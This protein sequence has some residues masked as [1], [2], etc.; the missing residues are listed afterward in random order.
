MIYL[1]HNSK[2]GI[3]E[4]G[5]EQTYNIEAAMKDVTVVHEFHMAEQRF[6]EKILKNLNR[7]AGELKFSMSVA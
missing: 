3:Y 4:M 7:A 2:L 6:A 1:W 5:D